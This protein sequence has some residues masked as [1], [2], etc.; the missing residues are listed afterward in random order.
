MPGIRNQQRSFDRFR[1]DYN[2]ERPHE[3]LG[4]TPPA[5][6]YEP[7]LRT[8]PDK[9]RELFY[10][11]DVTVRRVGPNGYLSWRGQYV[12]IANLL[13]SQPMGLC[14]TDE[15]EWELFYGPLLVGYLLRR[16]GQLRIEPVG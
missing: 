2:E 7:S 1:R 14:Q 6:H 12:R 16:N 9:P 13:A 3:A 11:A 10:P 15:D 8:M 5:A 4:Q